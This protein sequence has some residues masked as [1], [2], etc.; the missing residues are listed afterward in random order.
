[1][2]RAVYLTRQ[3]RKS[4]VGISKSERTTVEKMRAECAV[5]VKKEFKCASQESHGMSGNI[6]KSTDIPSDVVAAEFRIVV[7]SVPDDLESL[8]QAL[9][10][11]P[12]MDTATARLQSHLLPGIVPLRTVGIWRSQ[13]PLRLNAVELRQLRF[14]PA[15]SRISCM[16]IPFITCESKKM[17]WNHWTQVTRCSPVRGVPSR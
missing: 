2:Q 1:M 7:F 12:D 17:C 3:S 4:E 16:P 9:T 6:A 13:W 10:A 8:Q 14:R 15:T 11:L 5:V